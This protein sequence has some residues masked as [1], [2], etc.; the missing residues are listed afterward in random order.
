M[1]LLRMAS[2]W[3]YWAKLNHS[4][5]VTTLLRYTCVEWSVLLHGVCWVCLHVY[6]PMSRLEKSQAR[7]AQLISNDCNSE[8]RMMCCTH[9]ATNSIVR[10]HQSTTS[11]ATHLYWRVV[12]FIEVWLNWTPFSLTHTHKTHTYTHTHAHKTHNKITNTQQQQ[13]RSHSQWKVRCYQTVR[14]SSG[15]RKRLWRLATGRCPTVWSV[16]SSK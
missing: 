6:I 12:N 15:L 2:L 1:W 8:V 3:S 7:F 11:A 4:K 13:N 16:V 10:Y 14:S 5:C 9:T